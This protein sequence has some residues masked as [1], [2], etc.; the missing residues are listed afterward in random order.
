MLCR[1][2]SLGHP[3]RKGAAIYADAIV[4]KLKLLIAETG[5]LRDSR[6]NARPAATVP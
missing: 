6:T 4:G 2:A 1:Y 5:W 3:N